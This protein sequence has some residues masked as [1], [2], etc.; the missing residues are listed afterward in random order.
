MGGLGARI[1]D[2]PPPY[3][4]WRTSLSAWPHAA[5]V[6]I[7]SSDEHARAAAFVFE[8]DRR[9][10]LAAH[11][12]L[13]RVLGLCVGEQPETLRFG[14]G[15]YG[16][17]FLA[18]GG[19]PVAFNLSHSEDVALIAVTEEGD[20]GV[21]VEIDRNVP[22]SMSLAELNFTLSE[23]DELRLRSGSA[24]DTAFLRCWTRKEACLKAIGSGLGVSPQ[25]FTV[26][27]QRH[28]TR[29]AIATDTGLREVLVESL[30]EAGVL[31]AIARVLR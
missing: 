1:L 23:R 28:R 3:K 27:T 20:I 16:K 30:E 15:R 4:L 24:R 17:P 2:A 13:R 26:G 25:D 10:Y 12:A 19:S 5:D 6:G 11:V 31:G 9:R 8:R 18:N 29:V 22:D 7:L 14:I 21:D